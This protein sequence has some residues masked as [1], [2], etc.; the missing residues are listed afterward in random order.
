[1]S[2]GE[3]VILQQAEYIRILQSE[4]GKLKEEKFVVEQ[5]NKVLRDLLSSRM[6]HVENVRYDA[7]KFVGIQELTFKYAV[8]LVRHGVAVF[9]WER[10]YERMKANEHFTFSPESV[11]RS[12]QKLVDQ[13]RFVR[14]RLGEYTVKPI[15]VK[16]D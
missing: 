13:G 2:E 16:E 5:E 11:R 3:K 12:A 4:V 15:E 7:S 6:P 14:V 9:P 10:I 8:D 1:M